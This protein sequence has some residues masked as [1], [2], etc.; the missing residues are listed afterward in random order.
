MEES[1]AV[2]NYTE[3][4]K[5]NGI[6]IILQ[7]QKRIKLIGLPYKLLLRK[8]AKKTKY[9]KF[10]DMWSISVNVFTIVP[11]TMTLNLTSQNA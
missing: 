2:E 8:W 7:H 3:T 10:N 4:K 9:I 5:A 6:K 11:D 1:D